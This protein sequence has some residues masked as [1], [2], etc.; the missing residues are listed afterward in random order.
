VHGNIPG[1]RAN[2]L[3]AYG[4]ILGVHANVSDAHGNIPGVGVS[5]FPML[6]A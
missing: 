5:F 2:I 6:A 4:N 3:D 1:V